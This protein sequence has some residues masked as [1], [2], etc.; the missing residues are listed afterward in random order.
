M[1][2]VP[3]VEEMLGVEPFAHQAALHID[4]GHDDGVDLA[5]FDGGGQV[6]LA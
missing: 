4:L 3:A 5:R 6:F 2:L 1:G